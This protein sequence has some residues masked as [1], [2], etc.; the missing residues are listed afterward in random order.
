VKATVIYHSA[1]FDG[2]F[3]REIARKFLPTDTKLIGW[4]FGDERVA[5]PDGPIYVLDLPVDRVFGFDYAVV[6]NQRGPQHP[7]GLV[8]IDHHAS[9]IASHPTDIPGYRIDGVAACR[10]TFQWF[11][12]QWRMSTGMVWLLPDKQ[13]FIDRKV[14][15]PEAVRLAGEYDIWDKRDPRADV[16]QFGLRSEPLE[17]YWP[18]L[19]DQD[20]DGRYRGFHIITRLLGNGELLQRYQNEQNASVIKDLGFTFQWEGLTWLACNHAR[21]NSHLFTA[22]LRP[23]HDACF[24]FKFTGHCAAGE[25]CEDWS[26]SLYHAPGKEQYDLSKIAVK[27]GG[28]G[29]RGACGFRTNKLPFLK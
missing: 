3:C 21:Y 28:G 18:T 27:H 9:S 20:S 10:L 23:E 26:I 16:F 4:D 17:E 11:L 25:P 15:E 29:H 1:D 5:I 19:L 14:T 13:Q 24:G 7:A 8:W 12:K 2:I 6:G 22:G